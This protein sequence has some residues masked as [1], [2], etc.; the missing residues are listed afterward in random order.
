MPW[1]MWRPLCSCFLLS[2]VL[3]FCFVFC[4]LIVF[5]SSDFL[6]T[7][8]ENKYKSICNDQC[9]AVRLGVAKTLVLQFFLDTINV[10]S[11]KLCAEFDL[12]IALFSYCDYISGSQQSQ[13]VL[14][15]MLCSV[16]ILS[17]NCVWLLLIILIRW[18]ICHYCLT[19]ICELSWFPIS[20]GFFSDT[21]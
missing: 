17:E 12:L 20:V 9:W 3:F 7:S 5:L 1:G 15:N 10:I 16:L 11:V 14:S 21:A 13:M 18:W 4:S 6:L 2:F 19:L 8:C